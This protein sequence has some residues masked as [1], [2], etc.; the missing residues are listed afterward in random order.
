MI[1]KI[2]PIILLFS[3]PLYAEQNILTSNVNIFKGKATSGW[4]KIVFAKLVK[5]IETNKQKA[6]EKAIKIEPVKIEK[7]SKKPV[8]IKR[9]KPRVK[10]PHV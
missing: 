10:V 6:L 3:L 4:E 2:I 5:K 8:K 7:V 1:L 9:R